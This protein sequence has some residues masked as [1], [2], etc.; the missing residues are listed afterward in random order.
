MFQNKLLGLDCV[1]ICVRFGCRGG[2]EAIRPSSLKSIQYVWQHRC[3][4]LPPLTPGRLPHSQASAHWPGLAPRAAD[5][6]RQE[7]GLS[8]PTSSGSHSLRR[9]GRAG[10]PSPQ[11]LSGCREFRRTGPNRFVPI[12]I[13]EICYD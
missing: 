10:I 8:F 11:T 1:E 2:H 7:Q 9:G 12:S 3:G 13:W 6:S 5:Q 4:T